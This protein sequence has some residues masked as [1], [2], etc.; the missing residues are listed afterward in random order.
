M[1]G[2][3]RA[4]NKKTSEL[5]A[6]NLKEESIDESSFKKLKVIARAVIRENIRGVKPNSNPK[7]LYGKTW[8]EAD[9][10]HEFQK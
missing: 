3:D 1:N 10:Y 4:V 6:K 5:I 8:K 2:F 7:S 9:K